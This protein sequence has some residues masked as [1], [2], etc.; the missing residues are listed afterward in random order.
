MESEYQ[1]IKRERE[2]EDSSKNGDLLIEKVY[3]KGE[4]PR[5]RAEAFMTEIAAVCKKHEGAILVDF[6]FDMNPATYVHMAGE[7]FMYQDITE[8][9]DRLKLGIENSEVPML[10]EG[11]DMNS[12]TPG[13]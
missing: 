6:D 12:S 11:G 13:C 8:E 5:E 7:K 10:G 4:S 1:R 3:A 2:A 9:F